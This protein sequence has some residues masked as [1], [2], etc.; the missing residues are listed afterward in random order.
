MASP[1]RLRLGR[2]PDARAHSRA[3]ATRSET[4]WQRRTVAWRA[5]RSL[6]GGDSGMP[7]V[8]LREEDGNTMATQEPDAGADH[9]ELAKNAAE[10]VEDLDR[11]AESNAFPSASGTPQGAT[12][13]PSS[14]RG[15]GH[16]QCAPV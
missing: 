9:E 6:R 10:V 8:H 16:R 15:A 7:Y 13:T 2:V 14:R 4:L 12:L 5:S 1:P 3:D 11:M